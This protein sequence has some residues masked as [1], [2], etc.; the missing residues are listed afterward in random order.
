M[1]KFNRVLAVW[2]T[3]DCDP[4]NNIGKQVILS[5]KLSRPIEVVRVGNDYVSHVGII[6]RLIRPI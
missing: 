2:N 3:Y 6:N 1:T 5:W 4:R